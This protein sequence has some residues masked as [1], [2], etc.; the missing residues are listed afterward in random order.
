[1]FDFPSAAAAAAAA[2]VLVLHE[3]ELYEFP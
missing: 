1:M 3:A 2:V